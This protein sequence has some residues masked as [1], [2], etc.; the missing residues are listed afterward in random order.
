M[1][2][3]AYQQQAPTDAAENATGGQR[4]WMTV[5]SREIAVKLRDK[6][7]ILSTLLIIGVMA[8]SIGISIFM[9][10]RTSTETIAVVDSQSRQVV[11]SIA[12][13]QEAEDDTDGQ[14]VS[15]IQPNA[16][17]LGNEEF[18]VLGVDSTEALEAAVRDGEAAAGLI[19]TP[20]GWEIV[21]DREVPSSVSSTLTAVV[22]QMGM[23]ENAAAAGTSMADLQNGTAPTERLLSPGDEDSLPPEAMRY[24]AA[25]VFGFLFYFG[26]MT[27]GYAISSSVVEEKQSRIVE[28]LAA[29]VPIR[30]ILVGKIVGMTILATAQVAL[31]A[32]IGLIGV[33]FTEYST[34]L[35]AL[36]PAA[37]WYVVFFI[38]GFTAVAALFAAAGALASRAEDLQSTT[39]P[40]MMIVM[41]AFFGSIF[42]TG[43]FQTVFSYFPVASSILMP[44]RLASGTAEW[45]EAAIALVITVIAT[46]I[47]IAISDLIYR[48]SLMQTSRKMTYREALLGAEP[49]DK[50]SQKDMM[51][52]KAHS[53]DHEDDM[54]PSR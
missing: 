45:W 53:S 12:Q 42:A 43:T 38:F 1:S 47:I 35:T 33:S 20:G 9:S 18:E 8:V 36:A 15:T 46:A 6:N 5:A 2:T 4:A 44:V 22:A 3:P 49:K 13:Q 19:H 50:K 48:R 31:L 23:E 11:E 16:A 27:F 54:A 26:V 7:F 21:G 51:S 40:L 17:M 52:A 32:I 39:S 14:A 41:I 24:L 30:E 28:I 37:G 34:I 10:N 25:M 29:A